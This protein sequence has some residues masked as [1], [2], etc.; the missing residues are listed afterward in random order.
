M[1]SFARGCRGQWER[2][3]ALNERV[4]EGQQEKRSV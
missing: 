2:S 3:S 1:L 4:A